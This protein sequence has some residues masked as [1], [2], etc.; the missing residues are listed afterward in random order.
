VPEVRYSINDGGR[1]LTL[2][3]HKNSEEPDQV[4]PVEALPVLLGRGGRA[5]VRIEDPSVSREHARLFTS[6][7]KLFIA[8][9]NSSNGTYLNGTKVTR[10]EV[11]DGDTIRLG[12]V[13]LILAGSVTVAPAQQKPSAAAAALS[14]ENATAPLR[15]KPEQHDV[16]IPSPTPSSAPTPAPRPAAAERPAKRSSRAPGRPSAATQPQAGPAEA[17]VPN[18]SSDIRIKKDFLQYHKISPRKK[19]GLLLADFSQYHPLIRL[20]AL[21]A[22]LA[23][24]VGLFFLA[25]WITQSTVPAAWEQNPEA[26]ETDWEE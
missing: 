24:A 23:V 8:D 17:A 21:L 9:L 25:K 11:V 4:M 22:V 12:G 20:V 19:G 2:K 7:G 14:P 10:A 6:G 13:E 3:L 15:P 16:Q 18:S 26:I 1:M 5:T